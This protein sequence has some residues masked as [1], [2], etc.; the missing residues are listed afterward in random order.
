MG[1]ETMNPADQDA[2]VPA[3]PVTTSESEVD[4]IDAGRVLI[5]VGDPQTG[6]GMPISLPVVFEQLFGI[7]ADLDRRLM[8]LEAG[9]KEKSRIIS[10]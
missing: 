4:F 6:K 1:D 8:E 7:L 5:M 2:E 10:L 9:P 3:V